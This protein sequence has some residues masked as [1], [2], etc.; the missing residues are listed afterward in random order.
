VPVLHWHIGGAF[1]LAAGSLVVGVILMFAY[2]PFS[3]AF[4]R[5]EVLNVSTA[6]LVPEDVGAPIG[7]FGIDTYDPE[8]G[9]PVPEATEA[10][11]SGTEPPTP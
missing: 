8:T 2:G 9:Q 4:F 5:G 3:P 11:T 1:L 6:T 10:S 7:L